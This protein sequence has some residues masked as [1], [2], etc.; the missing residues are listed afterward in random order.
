M[1]LPMFEPVEIQLTKGRKTI[2]DAIDSDLCEFKWHFHTDKW[3]CEYAQSTIYK[4]GKRK[5]VTIHRLIFEK[6]VGRSLSSR[7]YVDHIDGDG[8]N[9]RRDNLRLSS[10]SQNRQNSKRPITN[11]S[12]Y[13][14][15]SVHGSRW[16][17]TITINGRNK[18]LG[19]FDTPSE[20]HEA[21]KKAAV[22]YFG[23]FARFE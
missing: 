15:V 10:N 21:Y 17:A 9:N 4:E 20:A 13:K 3:G 16:C 12:G 6:I 22:E 2:V 8:L 1:Q 11:T 18:K 23:E 14:G 7:E 5:A 19:Y